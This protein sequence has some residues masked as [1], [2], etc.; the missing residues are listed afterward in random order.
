M[1]SIIRILMKPLQKKVLKARKGREGKRKSFK[2]RGIKSKWLM[3]TKNLN[4][5]NKTIKIF[6]CNLPSLSLRVRVCVPLFLSRVLLVDDYLV[7]IPFTKKSIESCLREKTFYQ[8]SQTLNI[9]KEA[10]LWGRESKEKILSL[11]RWRQ[12][13]ACQGLSVM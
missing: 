2:G 10:F 13:N 7:K 6:L 4:Y 5:R 3:D 8:S 9:K 1:V 12:K 11:N